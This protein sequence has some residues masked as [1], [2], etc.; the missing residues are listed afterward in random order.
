MYMLGGGGGSRGFCGGGVGNFVAGSV[1][2]TFCEVGDRYFGCTESLGR[3][4]DR[5]MSYLRIK[6]FGFLS[7]C[8]L[9]TC[10]VM[11]VVVLVM[12]LMEVVVVVVVAVVV[13]VKLNPIQKSPDRKKCSSSY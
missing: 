12:P 3:K 2:V 1:V 6:V 13:D 8:L 5:L 11:L 10:F 9:Y 4:C 7:L